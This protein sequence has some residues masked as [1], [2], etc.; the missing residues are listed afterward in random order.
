MAWPISSMIFVRAATLQSSVS[1]LACPLREDTSG[2]KRFRTRERQLT[3]LDSPLKIVHR[4]RMCSTPRMELWRR[5]L[6]TLQCTSN[7]MPT[8]QQELR[9]LGAT[10]GNVLAQSMVV[11]NFTHLVSARCTFSMVLRM[12]FNQSE[13]LSHSPKLCLCKKLLR[14]RKALNQMLWAR[15]RTLAKPRNLDH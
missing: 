7:H 14:T 3:P 1:H 2:L 6:N 8:S 12:L 5:S 15:A 13:Q 11:P 9:G 10:I 4:P